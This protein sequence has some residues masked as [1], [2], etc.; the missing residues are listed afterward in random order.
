MQSREQSF[1]N[2]SSLLIKYK[3]IANFLKK[4]GQSNGSSDFSMSYDDL[5]EP[6]IKLVSDSTVELLMLAKAKRLRRKGIGNK[7]CFMFFSSDNKMTE[8]LLQMIGHELYFA[9]TSL[10]SRINFIMKADK[11][12][13]NAGA[14]FLNSGKASLYFVESAADES[15]LRYVETYISPFFDN[16]SIRYIS[17]EDGFRIQ[18][19]RTSCPLY[20]LVYLGMIAKMSEAQLKNLTAMPFSFYL[21]SQSLT[22]LNAL[23]TRYPTQSVSAL[24]TNLTTESPLKISLSDQIKEAVFNLPDP[25]SK[26][27]PAPKKLQ[28]KVLDFKVLR[29]VEKASTDMRSLGEATRFALDCE[30]F[31][32]STEVQFM[33]MVNELS[34]DFLKTE[35]L[36]AYES[37][38]EFLTELLKSNN[39]IISGASEFIDAA[40]NFIE[41]C[42]DVSFQDII[43]GKYSQEFVL[44]ALEYYD[45]N[46][47]GDSFMTLQELQE[48]DE[49]SPE[50]LR[51]QVLDWA[52]PTPPIAR[53]QA[54]GER[55]SISRAGNGLFF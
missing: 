15:N 32:T 41:G 47:G 36:N 27:K 21:Y 5:K 48:M 30:K 38:H 10:N 1:R 22:T 31:R 39:Y 26:D 45:K 28:P 12:H 37:N 9:E 51:Y 52:P 33:G 55:P 16:L 25:N 11:G 54:E 40:R 8:K 7:D 42:P 35:L 2:I 34:D 13:Y 6:T 46:A 18:A 49:S 50:R 17:A 20:S 3:T 44:I 14:L 4:L 43:S 19:D 24:T 53:R 23:Q 29:I